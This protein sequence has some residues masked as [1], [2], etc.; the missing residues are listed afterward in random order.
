MEDGYGMNG[1]GVGAFDQ[2]M[3]DDLM[4]N[5]DQTNTNML[6]VEYDPLAD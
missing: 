5:D 4:D 1:M 6:N 3:N 2:L